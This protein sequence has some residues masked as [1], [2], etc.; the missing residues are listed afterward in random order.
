MT[1][2]FFWLWDQ[3]P[4]F[5]LVLVTVAVANLGIGLGYWLGPDAWHSSPSFATVNDTLPWNPHLD[6][7]VVGALLVLVGIGILTGLGSSFTIARAALVFGAG[8]A[9]FLAI[10]QVVA[11]LTDTLRGAAG[12]YLWAFL[13]VCQMAQAGEP[14]RNPAAASGPR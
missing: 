14:P 3:H 6:F 1:R 8:F 7:D 5:F 9:F 13:A 12:P 10:G 11:A 4:N 2:R